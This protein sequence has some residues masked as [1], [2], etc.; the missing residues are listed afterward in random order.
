MAYIIEISVFCSLFFLFRVAIF[1]YRACQRFTARS[2]RI[3]Y[4]EHNDI[5]PGKNDKMY[6]V[7]SYIGYI[8]LLIICIIDF[9]YTIYYVWNDV[10]VMIGCVLKTKK[11]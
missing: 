11:K 4:I 1:L 10:C 2:I 7:V 8:L 9:I 6:Q 3:T 5:I